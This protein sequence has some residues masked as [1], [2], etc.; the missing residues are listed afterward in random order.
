MGATMKKNI[1]T[2]KEGV[3]QRIKEILA[4][5]PAFQGAEVSVNFKDKNK[6]ENT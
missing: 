6:K 5:H 2:T 1:P 3:E 4:K